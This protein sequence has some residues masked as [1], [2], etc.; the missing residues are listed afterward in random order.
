MKRK[1]RLENN[2]SFS[3]REFIQRGSVSMVSMTIGSSLLAEDL[4][5]PRTQI[6]LITDLHFADKV[7]AGSRHYRESLP[8]LREASGAFHQAETSHVIELGDLIDAADSVA[9]E[10][11]Y[12]ATIHQEF[13][14]IPGRKHYVLGN[15]CVDTLT[16]EEFLEGVGAKGSY[17]SFDESGFHFIVLDACFRSDGQAYQRR[18]FEWT[19]PNIPAAELAWLQQDLDRTSLPT[20]VFVH[21]RLDVG[22]PYGVKN[23]DAVRGLLERSGKVVSVFQGHSHK[24][25][26]QV[27]NGIHYVTL[28]AMVEGSGLEN[29]GYSLLK[30]HE[31]GVVRLV[32][33]RK[34][35]SYQW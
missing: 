29:S 35:S 23:A 26:H 19:D 21:Q 30:L 20:L 16:K 2:G 1:L 7:P 13:A 15:H 25:Q 14:K 9:K 8:K 5:A 10:Q 32:G 6:G 31:G 27:I 4:P 34:Q 12:L 22:H 18:N 3:R 33:M 17:E 28:K 11:A 24:N